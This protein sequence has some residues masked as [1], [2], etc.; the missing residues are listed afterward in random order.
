MMWVK[1]L[2]NVRVQKVRLNYCK[3]HKNGGTPT[4]LVPGT[5]VQSTS[6]PVLCRCRWM[7]V[8]LSP[9]SVSVG[10]FKKPLAGLDLQDSDFS[11]FLDS[12]FSFYWPKLRGL[13]ETTMWGI[14]CPRGKHTAWFACPS[15]TLWQVRTSS[16]PD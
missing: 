8:A 5:F 1:G 10:V 12:W 6:Q 4:A 2:K 13:D 3:I 16:C 15:P 9:T 14:F 7:T 11:K